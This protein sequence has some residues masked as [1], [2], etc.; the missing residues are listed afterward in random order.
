MPRTRVAVL[1]PV[2]V[3][4]SSA[5]GNISGSRFGGGERWG[6]SRHLF[7]R[8]AIEVEVLGNEPRRHVTGTYR[9]GSSSTAVSID[10]ARP[11]AA[12]GLR[13]SAP[14]AAPTREIADHVIPATIGGTV[15]RA[16]WCSFSP[17][18]SA[19]SKKVV[20]WRC[21][22]RST[23]RCTSKSSPWSRA[24]CALQHH[25]DVLEND[26]DHLAKSRAVFPRG[27]AEHPHDDAEDR[28]SSRIRARRRP[29]LFPLEHVRRAR[30]ATA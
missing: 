3:C 10:A 21:A 17:S 4:T 18:S 26:L 19:F 25:G 13:G 6:G 24:R 30:C 12:C 15:V 5:S 22:P 2:E 27:E 1:G 7:D 9:A 23:R 14:G 29:L 20:G 16:P 8:A 28:M 11:R